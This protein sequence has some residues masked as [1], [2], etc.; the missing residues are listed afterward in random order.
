LS[1]KTINFNALKAN[2]KK[3]LSQVKNIVIEKIS[4]KKFSQ[5]YL[6]ENNKSLDN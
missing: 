1:E 6:T 4:G 2:K 3:V 5:K